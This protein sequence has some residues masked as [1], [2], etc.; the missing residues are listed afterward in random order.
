MYLQ[1][2]PVLTQRSAHTERNEWINISGKGNNNSKLWDLS[3]FLA[4][5]LGG[6]WKFWSVCLQV[7]SSPGWC[8]LKMRFDIIIQ[9][10]DLVM[11]INKSSLGLH[12]LG[13]V[14]SQRNN[15]RRNMLLLLSKNKNPPRIY[16]H[17]PQV[18]KRKREQ[19][20]YFHPNILVVFA[21]FIS[22]WSS[23][24]PLHPSSL[25]PFVICSSLS[26]P[27][28]YLILQRKKNN[29]STKNKQKTQQQQ[30]NK[31]K[32]PPKPH[33]TQKQTKKPPQTTTSVF[34]ANVTG[35]YLDN[36]G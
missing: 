26:F 11:N 22:L 15:F 16:V 4:V 13:T 21:W 9:H 25:P 2:V 23:Q 1:K 28:I 8:L 18:S 19:I 34:L 12:G 7:I 6:F 36:I 29:K 17:N 3:G 31:Q 30:Q 20:S 14:L 10:E 24:F 27:Y 35:I 33:K 32:R 5:W